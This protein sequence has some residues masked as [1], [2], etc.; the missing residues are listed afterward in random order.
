MEGSVTVQPYAEPI[1]GFEDYFLSLTPETNTR[2]PWF[3][4]YWEDYFKCRMPN[5]AGKKA[6]S[7]FGYTS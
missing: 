7:I 5:S 1:K 6:R 2:N 3:V 4:E